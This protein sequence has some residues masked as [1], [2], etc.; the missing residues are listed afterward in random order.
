MAGKFGLNAF[1]MISVKLMSKLMSLIFLVS[2]TRFSKKTFFSKRWSFRQGHHAVLGCWRYKWLITIIKNTLPG[3][4][5][6]CEP[7]PG[8]VLYYMQR[9]LSPLKWHRHTVITIYSFQQSIT[10]WEIIP[11]PYIYSRHHFNLQGLTSC[12]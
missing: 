8:L 2:Y 4:S 9:S 10:S 7:A 6:L 11:I 1:K 5:N 3:C 12:T